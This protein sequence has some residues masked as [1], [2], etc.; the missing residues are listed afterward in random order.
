MF[1]YYLFFGRLVKQ[2]A[3]KGMIFFLDPE[4]KLPKFSCIFCNC[5][6]SRPKAGGYLREVGG[7]PGSGTW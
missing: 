6:G 1:S 7:V 2:I 4:Q 5:S 3:A